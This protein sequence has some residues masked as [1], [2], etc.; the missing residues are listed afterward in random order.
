MYSMPTAT[1]RALRS[2]CSSVPRLH[3]E[4]GTL[5]ELLCEQLNFI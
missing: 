3:M 2:P 4:T 5:K 1:A